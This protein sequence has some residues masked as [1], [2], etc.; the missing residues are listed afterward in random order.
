M[1]IKCVGLLVQ[2]EVQSH[3]EVGTTFIPFENIGYPGEKSVFSA[4][5]R[6]VSYTHLPTSDGTC[7][8]DYIHV[9][10]LAQAHILAV[11]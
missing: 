1:N 5:L 11:E 7:I 6:P 4:R 2:Q 9:T 10:D 8:R 3:Y